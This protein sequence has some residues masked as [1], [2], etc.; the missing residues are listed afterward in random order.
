MSIKLR[1][2]RRAG[3]GRPPRLS[4]EDQVAIGASIDEQ[5]RAA[6]F[7]KFKASVRQQFAD[8]D[9]ELAWRELRL[10]PVSQ[11]RAH[12]ERLAK[13]GLTV[14]EDDHPISQR[15]SDVRTAIGSKRT[16]PNPGYA[17]YGVR[18]RVLAKTAKERGISARMAE[19]CLEAYRAFQKRIQSE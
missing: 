12:S 5:M 15:L 13:S 9:L 1:G 6:A 7:D 10:I 4:Y 18:A 14:D 2:G 17:P 16:F 19:R 11:R 8:E 3:A